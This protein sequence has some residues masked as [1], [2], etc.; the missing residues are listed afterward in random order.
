M[1]SV[2]EL[3]GVVSLDFINIQTYLT[4]F[5]SQFHSL[6]QIMTLSTNSKALFY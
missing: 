3:A 4:P 1:G 2:A 6:L 5:L